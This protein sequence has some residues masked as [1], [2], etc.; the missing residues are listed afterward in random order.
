MA[1]YSFLD[2]Q[3][4]IIGP[5]GS[6]ALASGAGAAKEGIE[7][8]MT[9]EKDML[10]IGA[11]GAPMHSLI[12]DRSG[13]ITVH[14]L[15]TSPVNAQ[16][17]AMYDA[18]SLSAAV[19]GQNTITV[20]QSAAGDIHSCRSVAFAKRPDFKYGSEADTNSWEFN[21]GFIDGVLGTY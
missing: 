20:T 21:A 4:S 15:K 19:W 18:Q 14:L 17:S 16:L 7:I 10:T 5:G 12:A 3:A 6:F 8:K 9:A 11:D 13:K 2:V 1:S